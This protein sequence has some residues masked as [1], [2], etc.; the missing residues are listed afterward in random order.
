MLRYRVVLKMKN[1]NKNKLMPH[2]ESKL[3]NLIPNLI[4]KNNIGAK[5]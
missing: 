2:C 3:E 1:K 4:P 5:V